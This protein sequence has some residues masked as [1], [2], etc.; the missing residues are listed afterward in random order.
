MNP[1]K[2]I[3]LKTVPYFPKTVRAIGAVF[4][5]F[6]LA[7]IWATPVLG[8]LFVFITG[9]IF[10][11]HYGFEISTSPNASREFVWGLGWKD[12]KKNPFKTVEFLFVQPGKFTY[13]TYGLREKTLPSFEGY[14]IYEGRNEVQLLTEVSKEKLV[15][16]L[17]SIA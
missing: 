13:L 9:V 2:Q 12:G 7:M 5:I 8:L 16:K 14:I 6:G 17:K 3:G 10:T 1:T 15:Q 4:C 11:T